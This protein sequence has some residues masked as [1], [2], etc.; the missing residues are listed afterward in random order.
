MFDDI[1]SVIREKIDQVKNVRTGIVEKSVYLKN[2][3]DINSFFI[4][5]DVYVRIN[6]V[7]PR[8]GTF[9]A[10]NALRLLTDAQIHR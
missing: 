9:C 3:L 5:I 4:V 10:L 7:Q 8:N 6:D 2:V 1:M